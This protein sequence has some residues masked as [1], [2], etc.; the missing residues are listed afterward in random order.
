[1]INPTFKFG[2]IFGQGNI[3]RTREIV[4]SN[5]EPEKLSKIPPSFIVM[6]LTWQC[7]YHCNCCIDGNMVNKDPRN[8][9]V[10]LI[11]DI[12]DYSKKYGIRGIMTMGG[13]V[14]LYREGMQTALEKSIE[15]KIPIKT[16][17]NGS[18]LKNYMPLI[19]ES[20]KIPGSML[21]ISINSDKE[22]YRKQTKGNFD[23]EEILKSIKIITGS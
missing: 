1:M 16:V 2:S 20:Y 23:L 6:D 13:E 5:R 9:D 7:N 11:E 3:S 4:M 18:Y 15:Y 17:S 8:L 22:N 21:R 14:F 19:I 12:F 10:E